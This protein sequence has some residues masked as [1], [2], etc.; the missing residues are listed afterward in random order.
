MQEL[1]N[2]LRENMRTAQA[3]YEKYANRHRSPPLAYQIGNKVFLNA[4]NIKTKRAC[5]KLDWI[6]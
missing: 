1:N 4:K 5:K 2:F 3:F 6:N